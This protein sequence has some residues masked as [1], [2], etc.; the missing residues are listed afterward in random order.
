[1]AHELYIENGKAAMM[2]VGTP[3]W[4]GLGIPPAAK[5]RASREACSYLVTGGSQT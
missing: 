3:P 1:M 5:V 4:H 2:Y